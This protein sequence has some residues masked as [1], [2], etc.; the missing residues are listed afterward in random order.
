MDTAELIERTYREC[1]GLFLT[2]GMRTYG[3][4]FEIAK[5]RLQEAF[6]KVWENRGTIRNA[7]PPGIRS[8]ALRVHRNACIDYLRRWHKER[9]N[10]VSFDNDGSQSQNMDEAESMADRRSDPLHEILLIEELRLQGAAIK[11]LP[12]KYRDVVRLSLMGVKRNAIAKELGIKESAI[13][14]LKA[15]G[16][17]KYEANILKL[18]PDRKDLCNQTPGKK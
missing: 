5:D 17:K 12:P 10:R 9:Q 7:T 13:H 18:D 14:N 1:N 11:L 2:I 3:F 16:L 8:F 6:I 4:S 15:R